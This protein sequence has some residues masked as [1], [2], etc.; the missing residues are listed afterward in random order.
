MRATC[1]TVRTR[2]T[3]AGSSTPVSPA[4]VVRK[5][6]SAGSTVVSQSSTDCRNDENMIAIAAMSEKL[7]TMAARL[8]AAWP[9][10]ARS[11]ASASAS[12]G[13]RGS[14]SRWKTAREMHGMS[15][16]PPTRRQAIAA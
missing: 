6:T 5:Y 16:M 7:A 2:S 11:W 8:T 9:G 14:G 12:C 1:G 4:C 15:A 13:L 10:A 3:N